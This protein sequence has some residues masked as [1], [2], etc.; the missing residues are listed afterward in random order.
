MEISVYYLQ[1]RDEPIRDPNNNGVST[2]ADEGT[3]R[4]SSSN[5]N[6]RRQDE[7]SETRMQKKL[8]R[9][10][11]NQA[12]EERDRQALLTKLGELEDRLNHGGRTAASVDM[13]SIGLPL[14]S[15]RQVVEFDKKIGG[16]NCVNV[17]V[18]SISLSAVD[19]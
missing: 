6:K 13:E 18:K 15:V 8:T 19:F 17:N 1:F 7:S 4:P 5:T 11:R 16:Q 2:S 14:R 3:D 10:L 9:I 12:E